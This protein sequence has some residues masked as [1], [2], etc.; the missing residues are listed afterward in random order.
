MGRELEAETR[1]IAE[2]LNCRIVTPA[3][4]TLFVVVGATP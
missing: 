1:R 4:S 3:D 2:S